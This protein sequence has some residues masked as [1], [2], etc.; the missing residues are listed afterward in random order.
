MAEH[1]VSV[2]ISN[3]QEFT[4]AWKRT[5]YCDIRESMLHA[6]KKTHRIGHPEKM[7]FFF[8]VLQNVVNMAR[9][10][11]KERKLMDGDFAQAHFALGYVLE[12]IFKNNDNEQH[13]PT[14]YRDRFNKEKV[15][16]MPY[17]IL[18]MLTDW[19]LY[20]PEVCPYTV[21]D[22]RVYGKEPLKRLIANFLQLYPGMMKEEVTDTWYDAAIYTDNLSLCKDVRFHEYF[23]VIPRLQFFVG[24]RLRE[25]LKDPASIF[26]IRKPIFLSSCFQDAWRSS[27]YPLERYAADLA[28]RLAASGAFDKTVKL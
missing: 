3:I 8:G 26:E 5:G 14:N 17:W 18:V 10:M 15:A 4:E 22:A 27:Q 6:L 28:V 9:S 23:G 24:A 2:D 12:H 1:T 13:D 19:S 20:D 11:G 7:Q 21:L 16:G 25:Y